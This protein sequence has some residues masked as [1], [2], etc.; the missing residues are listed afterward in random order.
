M[1]TTIVRALLE[2]G[3]VHKLDV[4]LRAPL[5]KAALAN[6]SAVSALL[7]H[8]ERYTLNVNAKDLRDGRTAVEILWRNDLQVCEPLLK[9]LDHKDVQLPKE[10][11]DV[12]D[13]PIACNRKK[14]QRAY[15]MALLRTEVQRNELSED[16]KKIVKRV[17][18][19]QAQLKAYKDQVQSAVGVRIPDK[20]TQNLISQ[21]TSESDIAQAHKWFD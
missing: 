16:K 18:E 3:A 10:F 6:P 2:H 5:L 4:N 8:S 15:G 1:E 7:D 13:L 20:A 9:L 21:Y 14:I 19:Q 12:E 17:E 11:L